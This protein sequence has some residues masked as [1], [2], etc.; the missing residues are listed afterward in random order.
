VQPVKLLCAVTA[1]DMIK[2]SPDKRLGS[3]LRNVASLLYEAATGIP[4]QNLERACREVTGGMYERRYQIS[5]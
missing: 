1:K 2:N 5:S 4:G 3:R